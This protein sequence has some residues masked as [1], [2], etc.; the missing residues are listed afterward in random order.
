MPTVHSAGSAPEY[1][2]EL[3]PCPL[4]G[5]LRIAPRLSVCLFVCHI[6]AYHSRIEDRSKIKL[7]ALGLPC[8]LELD[9]L[10]E[11]RGKW[12][13]LPDHTNNN[14]NNNNA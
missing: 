1:P 9:I 2:A 13:R 10:T 5:T 14:N 3:R 11:T 7:E 6:R 8:Q 12:S 4:K